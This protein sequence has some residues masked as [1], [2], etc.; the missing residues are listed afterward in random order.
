MSADELFLELKGKT[1]SN[2]IKETD[3]VMTS[4]SGTY[5]VADRCI[6]SQSKDILEYELQL[7]KFGGRAEVGSHV[8]P[9]A[10]VLP[11]NLPSSMQ[12][13]PDSNSRFL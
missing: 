11:G 7:G 3:K 9:F 2:V 6:V 10:L 12:V 13:I 8:F 4:S 1:S 5:T